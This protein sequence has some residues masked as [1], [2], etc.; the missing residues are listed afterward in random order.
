MRKNAD[1]SD[2]I[3]VAFLLVGLNTDIEVIGCGGGGGEAQSH[4]RQAT[5]GYGICRRRHK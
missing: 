2:V 4:T 3:S 5:K 1:T